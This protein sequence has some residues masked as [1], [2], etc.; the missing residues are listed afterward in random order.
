MT[1][2][3]RAIVFFG[4]GAFGVPTLQRLLRER[5]VVGVVTQPDKPAGRGGKL[6]PT[7]VALAMEAWNAREAAA[8]RA[9]VPVLK[10]MKVNTPDV[11]AQVRAWGEASPSLAWVVIAFGQKLG[12]TLLADR[13]AI[14]LHASLLPRWRG[15]APINAAMVAGD[16]VTGNSVITLADTMDAGLVLGQT[17]RAI[18]P[19]LTA[20]ELHDALSQDG[21]ELVLRVLAQ[22]REGT[23]APETQDESRVT[24]APKMAKG[25]GVVDFARPARECRARVHGLT[26][27]PGVT[28]AIAGEPVKLLRVREEPAQR[29]AD[30]SATSGV[31]ASA[32]EGLVTCGDGCLRLLEVQ[33]AG[34]KPMRWGDFVRGRPALADGALVTR[35]E[36]NAP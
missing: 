13:F 35:V 17:T 3:T 16:T 9:P 34:K 15:A 27:W 21:P 36:G 10:P 19:A 11:I 24:I 4:S 29:T 7:P 23:L 22:H 5:W 8:G 32:R 6:T 12:L 14:N 1:G 28:M 26:P 33:P 31:L 2:A 20:G 25:D 30:A 18:D